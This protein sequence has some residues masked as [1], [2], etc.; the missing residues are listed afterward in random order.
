MKFTKL[1]SGV[2]QAP[3]IFGVLLL[4]L[5]STLM[6]KIGFS[7]HFDDMCLYSVADTEHFE[8]WM[9]FLEFSQRSSVY[10]CKIIF[11]VHKD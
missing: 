1:A 9:N 2:Y 5:F 7:H 3:D 8:K 6:N 4:S 11:D 10:S